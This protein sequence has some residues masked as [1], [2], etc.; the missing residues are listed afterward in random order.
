MSLIRWFGKQYA[1]LDQRAQKYNVK[2]I[3]FLILYLCSF[4]LYYFGVYLILKGSGL[5]SV[6]LSDLMRFDFSG[7]GI[8][9][10]LVIWGLCVNRLAWALPYLYVEI[11]GKGLRWYIHLGVWIWIGG[12]I[13]YLIYF[14]L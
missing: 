8:N 12:S 5:F 13:G 10:T 14:K 6:R 7:L 9:N 2:P 1:R 4:L 3:V 11:M